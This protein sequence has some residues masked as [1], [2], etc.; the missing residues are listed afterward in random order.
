MSPPLARRARVRPPCAALC[1]TLYLAGGHALAAPE[2]VQVYRDD[3]ARTGGFGVEVNQN[4]VFSGPRDDEASG[5]LRPVHLYRLTPEFDYGFA[6]NWEVGALVVATVRNGEFDAHGLKAHMRYVAP[7]PQAQPFYW[8]FNFEAGWTDRH[9]EARP[10]TA[11]LRGIAGYEG[12]RWIVALNP[13]VETAADAHD[14]EPASLAL[15]GKVGYR[16]N[17]KLILGLESYN[18]F[19]PVRRFGPLRDEPQMLYAAADIDLPRGDLNLGI[20]RGLTGSADGW[21][22]KVVWG[23]PMGR[24]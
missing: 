4:Y 2:E 19:G 10:W 21:A 16:V 8:G 6:R 22:V 20:G 9:L 14:V 17:E 13:T 24:R 23:L 5:A 15:Q 1:A 18:E 11:E 12:R 3:V 7:R